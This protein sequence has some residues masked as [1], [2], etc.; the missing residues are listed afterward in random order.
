MTSTGI[1]LWG[2]RAIVRDVVLTLVSAAVMLLAAGTTRWPNGW[3]FIGL[4]LG[5]QMANHVVLIGANP[6]IL[7]ARG[8]MVQQGT[9]AF[10]R[11][12]VVLYLPISFSALVVAGLDA[13]RYEWSHMPYAYTVLGIALLVASWPLASWAMAVNRNFET[14]VRIQHDRGHQVC[15]AG[16]YR[17]VRHPGYTAGI[18]GAPSMPLILGSWWAFLPTAAYMLLFVVRTALEDRTLR[19]ELPGYADYAKSTRYRLIPGLW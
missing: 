12:F 13:V 19:E 11:A 7:N 16:P 17:F 3:L 2:V 5:F 9:K 8:K 1:N 18:L 6:E 14:T 4:G 15:T 10:D